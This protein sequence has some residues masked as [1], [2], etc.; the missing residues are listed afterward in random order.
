MAVKATHVDIGQ[1]MI[2]DA[3]TSVHKKNSLQF[4]DKF[5]PRWRWTFIVRKPCIRTTKS[6]KT[7]LI[8]LR[9][10]ISSC[11]NYDLTKRF[12]Q[13]KQTSSAQPDAC[14]LLWCASA[15]WFTVKDQ[16]AQSHHWMNPTNHWIQTHRNLINERRIQ[17][18][19]SELIMSF[20]MQLT[21][22]SI[23]SGARNKTRIMLHL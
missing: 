8:F 9:C 2:A 20:R 16:R 17:V 12:I 18:K 19:H 13:F 11:S 3:N 1:S 6:S 15:V 4:V 23:A 21:C 14:I 10:R 22:N 5:I 7:K